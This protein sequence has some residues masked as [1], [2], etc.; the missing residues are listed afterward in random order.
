[1]AGVLACVGAPLA[2]LGDKMILH[3]PAARAAAL[4]EIMQE[5]LSLTPEQAA[6]VREAA[7]K[8]AGETD[9]ARGQYTRRQL[10]K[11][12]KEIGAKRDADFKNILTAEQFAAYQ[13][14][15]RELLKAMKARMK[16][17]AP[18][19]QEPTAATPVA[20]PVANG[21]RR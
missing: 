19:A 5:R 13:K 11:Q 14:D 10:K 6:A 15:K 7:E 12:L 17:A 4:A 18:D 3:P 8:Y 20:T 1:L 2:A 9:V 16:G 21:V